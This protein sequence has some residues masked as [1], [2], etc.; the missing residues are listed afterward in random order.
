MAKINK[1]LISL[2][3]IVVTI[4]FCACSSVRGMTITNEDGTIDELIY[5][6]LDED[7]LN[8]A[9]YT[10]TDVENLKLD[11][12]GTAMREANSILQKFEAKINEDLRFSSQGAERSALLSMRNKIQIVGNN[13]EDDVYVIGLRFANST[14]YKYYYNI[15]DDSSATGE[16]EEHFLYTKITYYGLNIFV[17]YSELYTKLYAEFSEKYPEFVE[18]NSSELLYTYVTDL[19][20]EHSDADYVTYLDGKYYHTWIVDSEQVDTPITLYYNIANKANCIML[21][22]I[23]SIILCAVLIIVGIIID[24]KRKKQTANPTIEL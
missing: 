3:L 2:M 20:R 24:K 6:T 21:C 17:D 15:S 12:S 18:E 16:E 10:S 13:W 1:I 4:C 22:I 5:V 23:I 7:K 19:R 14:V 11:I 8:S 9:N